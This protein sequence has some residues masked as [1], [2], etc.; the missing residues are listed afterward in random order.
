W[1]QERALRQIS[2]AI[3]GLALSALVMLA[4]CAASDVG[5]IN[6]LTMDAPPSSPDYIP[7]LGDDGS[8]IIGL[9]F[10]GGGMRASA[11]SY[12]VLRALDDLVIDEAPYRRT[13][14]DNVR[15]VAGVSGGAVTASYFALKGRDGYRDFDRRFL[16]QDPETSMRTSVSAA[17][18]MRVMAW[19]RKRPHLVRRLAGREPV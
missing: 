8:T 14:V 10:S 19:R 11:F 3:R 15:M 12:G 9:A 6:M 4:G 7:D 18:L 13:M 17:N 2:G 1:R 16:Y 5:P